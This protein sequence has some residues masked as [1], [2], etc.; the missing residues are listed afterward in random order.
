MYVSHSMK[1]EQMFTVYS[2]FPLSSGCVVLSFSILW[3]LV[4]YN[5]CINL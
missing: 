1:F 5:N 3:F 2:L 4:I